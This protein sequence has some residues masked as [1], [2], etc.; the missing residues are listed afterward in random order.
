MSAMQDLPNMA[1]GATSLLDVTGTGCRQG[2]LADAALASST[3]F[4][5]LDAARTNDSV[6]VMI[7]NIPPMATF[8]LSP[9]TLPWQVTRR[10]VP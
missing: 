6:R 8:D 5:E 2:D 9:A 4:V 3:R 7:R 1:P 10:R